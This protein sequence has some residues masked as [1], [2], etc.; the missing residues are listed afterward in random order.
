MILSN[1][2]LQRYQKFFNLPPM[3][4]DVHDGVLHKLFNVK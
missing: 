4:Q 3:P 2:V 1:I